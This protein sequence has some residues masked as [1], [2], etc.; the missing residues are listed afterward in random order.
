MW[1][2]T[3][4]DSRSMDPLASKWCFYCIFK[5]FQSCSVARQLREH[6]RGEVKKRRHLQPVELLSEPRP[7]IY[8]TV[9]SGEK[10][11]SLTIS[12]FCHKIVVAVHCSELGTYT[13]EIIV[14]LQ[15]AMLYVCLFFTPKT[16]QSETAIMREIVDRVSNSTI[17]I[18]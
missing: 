11:F 2:D 17:R 14:I 9:Q 13:M 12:H 16:L 10:V 4:R 7:P 6:G 3:L 1:N 15:A 18:I 5:N 8:R